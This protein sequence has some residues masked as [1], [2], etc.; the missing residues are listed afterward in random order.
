MAADGD[1][2]PVHRVNKRVRRAGQ[3]QLERWRLLKGAFAS[4]SRLS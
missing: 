1:L 2:G 4:L 3:G